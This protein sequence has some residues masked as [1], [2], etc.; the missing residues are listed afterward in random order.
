MLDIPEEDNSY[1][2]TIPKIVKKNHREVSPGGKMVKSSLRAG[3]GGCM[4][5]DRA[6]RVGIQEF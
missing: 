1:D 3:Q 4:Q 5:F 2:G 6:L